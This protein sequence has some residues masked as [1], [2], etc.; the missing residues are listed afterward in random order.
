[1]NPMT[2]V[3]VILANKRSRVSSVNFLESKAEEE[4]VKNGQ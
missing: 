4:G 2:P 1:M 3:V